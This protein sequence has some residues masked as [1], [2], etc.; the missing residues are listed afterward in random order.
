MKIIY[1]NIIKYS[2]IFML[3]F[4]FMLF[5]KKEEITGTIRMVG[6]AI[7]PEI[8]ITTEERD[9]YFD[10]KFF[11]EYAKYVGQNITIKAKVKKDTIWLAD[12]S[13]SFDRYTIMWVEKQE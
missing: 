12:R 4:F 11:D 13:K 9:Y 1:K 3:V 2:Y 7:F 8:V 6:T 10:K 5:A